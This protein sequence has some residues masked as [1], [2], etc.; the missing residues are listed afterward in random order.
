M[1]SI[2]FDLDGVLIDSWVVAEASFLAA[3]RQLGCNLGLIEAFR[4]HAGRRLESICTDLLLPSE[5]P[6]QYR[7]QARQIDHLARPFAGVETMLD[8]LR[9]RT[10]DL[11]VLT[12]KDRE[13]TLRILA[14]TR[15]DRFFD[16]VVTPDDAP[17]KPQ[18]EGLWLCETQIGDGP[19][20]GFVGDSPADME[21]A[22]RA[23]R[24]GVLALWGRREPGIRPDADLVLAEPSEVLAWTPAAERA[25]RPATAAD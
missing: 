7:Q 22:R 13:R 19:C 15:L 6:A 23:G 18:P 12:G 5:F 8:A 10:F 14:D 9:Y 11:G 25:P 2:V 1:P 21:A 20:L 24:P 3:A 4:A 17:G 16:A